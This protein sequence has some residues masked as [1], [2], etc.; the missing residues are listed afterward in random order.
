MTE[1]EM[2]QEQRKAAWKAMKRSHDSLRRVHRLCESIESRYNKEKEEYE[3]IDRQLAM[4]DGR[5]KVVQP[6]E[7]KGR[8]PRELT[9]DEIKMIVEKL[10]YS[11]DMTQE[12]TVS[13][14]DNE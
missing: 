6:E 2:L 11:I 9:L 13:G 8:A 10:G 7:K 14:G 5:F 3:C 1:I 12:V 4:L